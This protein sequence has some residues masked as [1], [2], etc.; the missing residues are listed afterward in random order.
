MVGDLNALLSFAASFPCPH[1]PCRKE[2]Q[3]KRNMVS[4]AKRCPHN[5]EREQKFVCPKCQ[6]K[7]YTQGTLN[8][9]LRTK[10]QGDSSDE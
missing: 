2:F 1:S 4:H 5:K 8:T 3:A 7:Y 9:H 10:H 6:K